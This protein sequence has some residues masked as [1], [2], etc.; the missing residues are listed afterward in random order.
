MFTG[1]FAGTIRAVAAERTRVASRRFWRLTSWPAT[2][3]ARA[4]FEQGGPDGEGRLSGGESRPERML[5]DLHAEDCLTA[6]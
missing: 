1:T 4:H 3:L 6:R 5:P 2:R